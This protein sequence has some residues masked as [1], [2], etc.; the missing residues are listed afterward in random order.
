DVQTGRQRWELRRTNDGP[1]WAS[2]LLADGRLYATGQKGVTRVFAAN[3][4][5]YE[6]VAVNDLGEQIHATPAISNGEIFIRTW[7]ALYCIGR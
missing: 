4:D 2:L 5:Q 7:D 1:H 3:P 6:E